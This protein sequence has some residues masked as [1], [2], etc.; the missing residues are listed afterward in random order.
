MLTLHLTDSRP[1]T[2]TLSVFLAQRSKALDALLSRKPEEVASTKT[3]GT[4][5]SLPAQT[6]KAR[7]RTRKTIAREVWQ[8]ME[9]V[10]NTVFGTIGAARD[11]FQDRSPEQQSLVRRVLDYITKDE[12]SA[13]AGNLPPDLRLSTQRFLTALPSSSHFLLLPASLRQYKPYVDLSSTSTIVAQLDLS[14]K[15]EEWF[16]TSAQRLKVTLNVWFAE[17]ESVRQV[18]AV[19]RWARDVLQDS[20]HLEDH[21]KAHIESVLDEACKARVVEIWTS[22][23]EDTEQSFR[24]ALRQAIDDLSHPFKP[25]KVDSSGEPQQVRQ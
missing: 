8:V 1:L 25:P 24:S 10:L 16:R 2:E 9:A 3:V 14:R 21:E 17:L 23:L 12:T 13:F 20:S 6:Q 11:V 19:R 7:L 15:L 22:V 4:D 18:W 5:P